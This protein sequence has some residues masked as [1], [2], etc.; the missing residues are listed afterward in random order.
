[1]RCLK[2]PRQ[3]PSTLLL[4]SRVVIFVY[5]LFNGCVFAAHLSAMVQRRLVTGC[6]R[7]F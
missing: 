1:M 7:D 5:F 2:A 6:S 4:P 3:S